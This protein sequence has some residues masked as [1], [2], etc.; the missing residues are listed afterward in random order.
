M[1]HAHYAAE[2]QQQQQQQ[3]SV[4]VDIRQLVEASLATTS[5]YC[6]RLAR[7]G[8]H[9]SKFQGFAY[10]AAGAGEFLL[11]DT[12][13]NPPWKH[14]SYHECLVWYVFVWRL[15][16]KS[17]PQLKQFLIWICVNLTTG[18]ILTPKVWQVH[19]NIS[20]QKSAHIILYLILNN[21]YTFLYVQ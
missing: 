13:L 10:D 2:H 20:L 14:D 11:C 6:T 21:N 8:S 5:C 16:S 12:F 1:H 15:P 17:E 3:R 9:A 7:V 18:F 4:M 19:K